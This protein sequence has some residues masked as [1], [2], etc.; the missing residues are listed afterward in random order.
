MNMKN[1]A[2]QTEV[3]TLTNESVDSNTRSVSARGRRR[4]GAKRAFERGFCVCLIL[5]ALF[6]AGDLFGQ[7]AAVSGR[8]VDSQS[9]A[10]P[11]A[12]V[13]M[14]NTATKREVRTS[15]NEEGYFL[16]PPVAPGPYEITASAKGLGMTRLE[17]I[18]LEVGQSKVVTLE[19]KPAS[20]NEVV[21][22]I[23][24]PPQLTVDRPDRSVVIER[25]FVD[26]IPLNVRNPLQLINFSVAVTKGDDG[27]SGTNTVSQSRTNTFRINGAKGAT[28]DILIDGA[29]NTT[30]YYNE[31]AAVPGVDTIQEYRVYTSAYAPEFGRTSGG[32]VSYAMRSGSNDLHGSVFEF[33]R[34]SA[35][36]AN[37]FN[38]N[39]A[40]IPIPGFRRNQ[41]G[42]TLGGP[43]YLPKLYNGRNRTFFFTGFEGLRESAAGSFTGTMPTGLERVG[44]FSNTLD[45]NGALIVIY[46]PSTTRLDPAAPAGTTRYLR[47]PFAGNRIS[48]GQLNPIALKLLSYYPQPNQPG[49]GK[50]NTNNFFSSAPGI[51]NTNHVNARI[52]HQF[53]EHH[54]VFGH[55]DWFTNRPYQN[56]YYGNWLAP[57]FANNRIP[58]IHTAIHHVWSMSPALVFEH[59]FSYAHVESNRREAVHVTPATLGFPASVTPGLTAELTPQLTMTRASGLGNSFP[60]ESQKPSVWQY[61]SALTWLRGAHTFKFGFDSR[62]FTELFDPPL[63]LAIAATTN[64]TGGPNPNAAAAASDS[65]IA[66]LLLGAATVTSGYRPKTV[67]S[68][69]YFAL[70]AQDTFRATRKLTLTYGIRYGFETGTVED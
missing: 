2:T 42:F 48:S 8:V 55:Y 69:N 66:D 3:R 49:V 32:I 57:V 40:R 36:D 63:Q 28:T 19:L 65:G 45:T 16:L 51:T 34:N 5:S 6:L 56:N 67:A 23:A 64:F 20:V 43:V 60:Y 44:D 38:G 41:F 33:L 54:S 30:A 50:S 39:K 53:S 14:L 27:L 26:S 11:Q 35:L 46:D 21:E 59:H 15:S 24:T 37:S 62:H 58:G 68:H 61:A 52:D 1:T 4:A 31:A 10:V 9:R 13:V 25:S 12:E 22:V 70:F 29:T 17:G 18:T 7:T 47:T